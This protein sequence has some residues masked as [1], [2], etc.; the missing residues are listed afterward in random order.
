MGDRVTRIIVIALVVVLGV[1]IAQPYVD[2]LLFS[3][4]TPRTVQPRGARSVMGALTRLLSDRPTDG[5]RLVTCYRR[6]SATAMLQAQD[7]K[8]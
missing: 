1:Y 4:S 2:R 5:F 6:M 3:A 8:S 7:A